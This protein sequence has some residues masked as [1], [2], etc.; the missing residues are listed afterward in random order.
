MRAGGS[1]CRFTLR[2]HTVRSP[3]PLYH[4]CRA[5]GFFD[6][7]CSS[8]LCLGTISSSLLPADSWLLIFFIYFSPLLGLHPH[9]TFA[10]LTFSALISIND[11]LGLLSSQSTFAS[12]SVLHFPS[13][14][15]YT[16]LIT[17][18][19]GAEGEGKFKFGNLVTMSK[20]KDWECSH[21]ALPFDFCEALAPI[22]R[23]TEQSWWDGGK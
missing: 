7:W 21:A 19:W 9:L 11:A 8:Q 3:I 17:A 16:S 23:T 1:H 13:V 4:L 2:I 6:L 14:S 18:I 10:S 20:L 5:A 15:D 12:Q 22:S